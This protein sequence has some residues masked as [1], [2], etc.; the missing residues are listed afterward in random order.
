MC[1]CTRVCER[2]RNISLLVAYYVGGL[3]DHPRFDDWLG[4]LTRLST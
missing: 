1:E 2:K 4:G 3:Q